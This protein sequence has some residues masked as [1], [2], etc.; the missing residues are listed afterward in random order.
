MSAI[1][2]R[3]AIGLVVTLFGLVI[4]AI[5]PLTLWPATIVGFAMAVLGALYSTRPNL[6][7]RRARPQLP[8][9]GQPGPYPPSPQYAPPPPSGF[10]DLAQPPGQPAPPSPLFSPN[11]RLGHLLP[12]RSRGPPCSRCGTPLQ[13]GAGFCTKCGAPVMAA[14]APAPPPPSP[15]SLTQVPTPSYG[16]PAAPVP[17]DASTPGGSCRTC[18][19]AIVPGNP[20]CGK[21]GSRV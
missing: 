16:G 9:Q 20:F 8:Q 13:A 11:G 15:A 5:S 2:P 21:C 1:Q 17:P 6:F 18:G 19:A 4:L 3:F 12:H 7:G 10:A 14:P